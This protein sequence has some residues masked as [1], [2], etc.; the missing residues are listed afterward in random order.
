MSLAISR[1]LGCV[2]LPASVSAVVILLSA[3]AFDATGLGLETGS[4][5]SGGV[6]SMSTD[7]TGD[8]G[9]SSTTGGTTVSSAGSESGGASGTSGTTTSAAETTGEA[10]T[11]EASTSG[12]S[13]GDL[14]ASSTSTE[15]GPCDSPLTV[16]P[17]ADGDTFGDPDGAL[18]TCDPPPPGHVEIAG[19]CDDGKSSVFPGADELCDGVDNDCDLKVDEHSAA[20]SGACNGCK[21]VVAEDHVYYFCPD[22]DEQS[23]AVAWCAKRGAQL[24]S[25]NSEDEFALVWSQIKSQAGDFWIGAD[26]MEEEGVYVWADGTP[27]SDEDPRW[28]VDEPMADGVLLELDCVVLGGGWF[29][30]TPGRYQTALCNQLIDP[31]WIC[32]AELDD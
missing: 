14:T 2:F 19:D 7:A 10:S 5:E 32:E 18:E 17:D 21:T 9:Q 25:I 12:A 20:N 31:G 1:S 22:E 4:G 13:T 27:L 11:S 26:D 15:G 8:D 6:G 3:C 29:S 16:Y 24:V 30:S 23:S 28:A